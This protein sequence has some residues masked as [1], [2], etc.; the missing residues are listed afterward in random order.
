MSETLTRPNLQAVIDAKGGPNEYVTEIGEGTLDS[1]VF[2]EIEVQLT[3]Q[4]GNAFMI[5]GLIQK[6]IRREVGYDEADAYVKD[7]QA[8]ESY[9]DLL[10]HAM[11]TVV[12]L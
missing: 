9:D 3:G 1:P 8:S 2:S 10:Q 12:V 4:D 7:A 11:S 5:M 6:A